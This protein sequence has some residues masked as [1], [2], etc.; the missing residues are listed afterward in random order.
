MM[1]G[2][3][4]NFIPADDA[5]HV[6]TILN[7]YRVRTSSSFIGGGK[8]KIVGDD[9]SVVKM[10]NNLFIRVTVGYEK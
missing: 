9:G 5:A 2:N 10:E 1:D 4:H 6:R 3:I 8:Y 7:K